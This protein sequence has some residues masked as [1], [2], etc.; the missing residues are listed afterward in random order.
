MVGYR[1]P[2]ILMDVNDVIIGVV[3]YCV[4][5]T[6][7]YVLH[8]LVQLAD[9]L[10]MEFQLKVGFEGRVIDAD[11]AGVSREVVDD[12]STGLVRTEVDVQLKDIV[13]EFGKVEGDTVSFYDAKLLQFFDP[14]P[15]DLA[16][17]IEFVCQFAVA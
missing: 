3:F 7:T 2:L 9:M 16:R 14:V 5:K 17:G 8:Y 11:Q 10:Q 6:G 1:H 4:G 12:V 13:P 15:D